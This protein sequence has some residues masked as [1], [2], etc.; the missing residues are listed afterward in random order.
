MIS[1]GQLSDL[2]IQTKQERK[3]PHTWDRKGEETGFKTKWWKDISGPL[4]VSFNPSNTQNF[5]FS[6]LYVL[7]LLLLS[8]REEI[9]KS[10]CQ[11]RWVLLFIFFMM[12][13]PCST[14]PPHKAHKIFNVSEL[15]TQNWLLLNIAQKS[16]NTAF[17]GTCRGKQFIGSEC[18]LCFSFLLS[19]DW[20]ARMEKLL[21]PSFSALWDLWVSR[22]RQNQKAQLF[23]KE[24]NWKWQIFFH[25]FQWIQI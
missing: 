10:F 25:G 23:W 20:T 12:E 22:D 5:L 17:F 8:Y 18:W 9:C 14:I 1:G 7:H 16:C 19:N 6:S 13:I 2:K 21:S 15:V 24:D 3:E 11:P 4:I